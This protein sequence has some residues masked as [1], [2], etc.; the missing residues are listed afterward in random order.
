MTDFDFDWRNSN[1][2][3]GIELEYPGMNPGDEKFVSR[4]RDTSGLNNEIVWPSRLGGRTTYDGTVG[5]E[6]VSDVLDLEDA[7]NWYAGAIEFVEDEYG[8]E[9]QPT[10]LMANGS[11]AGLHLHLSS[12]SREQ[13]NALYQ[14]SQTAW[15]KVLFCSSIANQNGEASWPV[16][17][18]GRYCQMNFSRDR[19]SCVNHR[20]DGHYEWR[21]PEPMSAEHMEVVANFLRLFEQD[22]NTA[23]EY[24]QELLDDGDD[25]ITAI[26]RAE[27]T[28]MDIDGIPTVSRQPSPTDPEQFYEQ[29][30]S[31][32]SHPE[33]YRVSF[34]DTDYYVFES[35][36]D[37][38]FEA[39]GTTFNTDDVLYASTLERVQNETIAEDARNAFQ[40]RE[41]A[42]PRQTEATEELKKIIKKKKGKL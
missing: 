40:Q 36:M 6:I 16:F 37:G 21:M 15:A 11:T 4:G 1:L 13:A 10:G 30:S 32:W 5:L 9:H 28:G 42:N 39:A 38:E 35:R 33:V 17:R 23:T 14:L 19:Y 41:S 2:N 7:M 26:K 31:R 25:R 8:V 24:A 18:G 3:I 12:L 22:V 29:V 20:R 34:G 27:A